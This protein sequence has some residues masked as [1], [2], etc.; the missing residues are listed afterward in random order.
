MAASTTFR[1]D[2]YTVVSDTFVPAPEPSIPAEY[3]SY[4]EFN[5][6]YNLSEAS[7]EK[8]NT[9]TADLSHTM[10]RDT[11]GGLRVLLNE[12]KRVIDAFK[13]FSPRLDEIAPVLAKKTQMGGR[14]IFVGVGSSGRAA[15]D[16]AAKVTAVYPSFKCLGL[17]GGGDCALILARE[18]L[19]DS[20]KEGEVAAEKLKLTDLDS[21]FLISAS[22]ATSF[23][24]GFGHIAANRGCQVYYFFNSG[25]IPDRTRVLFRRNNN[26]VMPLLLDIGPQAILGSTRLQAYSI[27]CICFSY[28]LGKTIEQCGGTIDPD[29]MSADALSKMLLQ[30]I[31]K[32]EKVLPDLAKMIVQEYTTFSSQQSNF[33]RSKD[34]TE[35][36]YVTLLGTPTSG[37]E[38]IIDSVE[39]PPTFSLNPCRMEGEDP[40]KRRRP[41]Y[42]AYVVGVDNETA[43]KTV[44]GR[45]AIFCGDWANTSHFPL[46]TTTSGQESFEM[47]PKS[48][49]NCV[50]GV[51]VLHT[52]QKIYPQLV[53]KLQEVKC[54][55]ADTMLLLISEDTQQ[56]L[57]TE[58]ES[59]GAELVMIDGFRNDPMKLT[60]SLMLKW[61]C[62]LISNGTMILMGKVLDNRMIDVRPSNNKLIDRCMRNINAWWYKRHQ[63]LLPREYIYEQVIHVYER[64]K[65]D[66]AL[67]NYS[68]STMK[69]VLTMLEKKCVYERA[70]VILQGIHEKLSLL[71]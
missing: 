17:M 22:G 53:Q 35:A 11:V 4:S 1:T 19:E 43:W 66:F 56:S 47:R 6:K 27:A 21:I 24:V 61:S 70:I 16:L 20:A 13:T 23:N 8:D 65:K 36:G 31:D 46:S 25:E 52:G 67:G 26:P 30:G 40:K 62:N 44:L 38:L 54:M 42:Q 55:G 68:P 63:V 58:L 10:E 49:G 28:L 29:Q 33:R 50:I 34:E 2:F 14:T 41:E 64:Q 5:Q 60:S 9:R 12:E 57:P 45:D 15:I 48:R 37:R 69:I 18:E 39:V 7:T 3:L 59:V 51:D 71:I 32:I